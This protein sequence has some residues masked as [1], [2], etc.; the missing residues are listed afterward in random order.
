MSHQNKFHKRYFFLNF[1]VMF[2]LNIDYYIF[3]FILTFELFFL[4]Y[5]S[6]CVVWYVSQPI[7][8]N[9]VEIVIKAYKF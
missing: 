5:S 2:Y 9:L 6:F 4:E 8:P 1:N 7:S 3:I